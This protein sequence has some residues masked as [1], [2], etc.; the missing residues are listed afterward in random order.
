M[1][2]FKKI[3]KLYREIASANQL[4]A[5]FFN[6]TLVGTLCLALYFSVNTYNQID[7]LLSDKIRAVN[8]A[9]DITYLDEVL[10][11]SALTYAFT[12]KPK[13][14]D[15]Y[16]QHVP[17]LDNAIEESFTYIDSKA[18]SSF[19][20][21]T[22]VANK[23]L[24]EMEE[25]AF[26][27][28]QQGKLDEAIEVLFSGKYEE[29]KKTYTQSVD[30][31]KHQIS[32]N[33]AKT[34]NHELNNLNIN[35]RLLALSIIVAVVIGLYMS[36]QG[37]KRRIE[38]SEHQNTLIRA[39]QT[40][41]EANRLKSEFL[42][43]MSHEIRTPMNG[44]IGTTQLLEDTLLSEEQ[45]YYVGTITSS[46]NSL[47][48]IINNILDFSKIGAD[49]VE[50]ESIPFDL[51]RSCQES[52]ELVNG[53]LNGKE[54]ELIFD[55]DP[56]CSRHLT[57]DPS[58]IRQVLLNLL[59]NAIKF[60]EDGFIRLGVSCKSGYASEE[61]LRI[62]VQ[63]T[64]I[65]LEPNSIEHLFDD[66]TQA[67]SST[68]RRFG[69]T[70][71]G[72]AITK[73]LVTLM[74]GDIGVNSVYGEGTTFWIQIPLSKAEIPI[75][76][77]VSSLEG[78]RILFVDDNQENRRIFKR[79]LEHMGADITTLSD[80]TQVINLLR[81]VSPPGSPY[82]IVILDHNMKDMSGLELG[83]DIRN[84]AQFDELK[85]LI[86]SS[87]GEKGDAALF[88]Q[89]G[90]NA[91]LNKLS[92][93]D[94]LRA[95][96]S[97]VLKHIP[98]QPI[99]TQHTIED[100]RKSSEEVELSIDA[101][102]L[103]VEDILPNQII[104]KKFLTNFGCDV[105]VAIN[106][107]EAVEAYENNK[108]DLVFMDCRMPEMDGYEATRLI[109]QI[110]KENNKLRMPII[111]LTANAFSDDRILC[112]EAGMDDMVTKPFRRAD[113]STCLQQWLPQGKASS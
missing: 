11:M 23:I 69:G 60:T 8:L 33:V 88:A 34:V 40:A 21:Q 56:D 92:R 1:Y 70:G 22:D 3:E 37:K 83:I 71:L 76:T 86:F 25:Q 109:R 85:L 112:D 98:D 95:I 89:A 18:Q 110:E 50:I 80:P 107:K 65:G 4:I 17:L 78:V 36:K 75:P 111:A 47:L 53:N 105:D 45:E 96:L 52:M 55:F 103:L 6:L 81:N 102:I 91:Y 43:T 66:F 59:G 87:V 58:R 20:N 10:T 32:L 82:K 90:F 42:A 19:L 93:Y 44:I 79:M 62:E 31:L 16:N 97:S 2:Q 51:E 94:T 63:D 27:L 12:G 9:K 30:K 41:E 100:A 74:G 113:L 7:F 104:A 29:N 39:R 49:M 106:G 24:L 54:I 61:Q 84:L 15:R 99:I 57:G 5:V 46:G 38:Q 26:T 67:D 64:G 101:S 68:T 14:K 28:S 72:L 108:Y 13:W 77:S 48:S 35:A 73:K